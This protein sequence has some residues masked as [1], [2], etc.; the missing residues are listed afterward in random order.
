ML[1]S[2]VVIIGGGAVGLYTASLLEKTLDVAVLERRRHVGHKACSGL[3]STKI[4]RFVEPE[5]AVEHEVSGAVLH[6]PG[7]KEVRLSKGIPA[8]YVIDRKRFDSMLAERLRRPVMAGVSATD[9]RV[10]AECVRIRTA[11]GT[12][13]SSVVIGC[14]GAGSLAARS[15][16]QRP[17]ELLTGLIAVAAR[18]DRSEDVELFFDK[19]FVR[20]GFLWKIPRGKTTEYGAM[21]SGIAFPVLERFFGMRQC[22]RGAA[23]IPIGPCR[24]F[25]DRLLLVG[26]AAGQA[27][28]WSGGGI[29]FGFTAA[30]AAASV[31][32]ESFRRGDFSARALSAYEDKWKGR[33]GREISLGLVGREM[34]KDMTNRQLDSLFSGLRSP[35]LSRMDMDFPVFSSLG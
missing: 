35:E 14:D 5:G 17:S 15:I 31:V 4:R 26:D 12:W 1:R 22:R 9:V 23:P 10:S 28:P 18:E 29:I 8:A 13:E 32:R 33:I 6:S 34:L 11:S 20:D 2:D 3:I 30:K 7:G 27:K 25:S 19:R 21:G 16:G 24:T